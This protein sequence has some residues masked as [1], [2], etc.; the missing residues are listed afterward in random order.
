LC[1]SVEAT[2]AGEGVL[3]I[4]VAD[5]GIGIAPE[6]I[7]RLFTPFVQGESGPARR[8]DGSGLGLTISRQLSQL[9]GGELM[10]DSTLGVGTRV[11]LRVPMPA[12]PDAG[13]PLSNSER[14]E[15]HA[16]F[17]LV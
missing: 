3:V 17:R 15:H 16:D 2:N 9:M 6:D 10:L 5:T 1:A 12:C 14:R 7:A 4:S 11:T 13:S 8:F